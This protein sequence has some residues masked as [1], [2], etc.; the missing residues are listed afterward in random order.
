[1]TALAHAIAL[2]WRFQLW[3]AEVTGPDCRAARQAF[4]RLAPLT[5]F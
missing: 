2:E 5:Y 1:M 4:L 3:L